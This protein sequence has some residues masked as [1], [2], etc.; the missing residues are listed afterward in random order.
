MRASN[1]GPLGAVSFASVEKK[2]RL[3]SQTVESKSR[4]GC[5]TSAKRVITRADNC[6]QI[7]PTVPTRD[8]AYRVSN[9]LS[10]LRISSESSCSAA[11]TVELHSIWLIT[12]Y[13]S[14]SLDVF[15]SHRLSTLWTWAP[16]QKCSQLVVFTT[17]KPLL[18]ISHIENSNKMFAGYK[19]RPWEP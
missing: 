12:V 1:F 17:V 16:H 18:K 8:R 14:P 15:S 11:S 13:R 3:R 2:S 6:K 19:N 4:R 7:G 9:L 5:N 10:Q